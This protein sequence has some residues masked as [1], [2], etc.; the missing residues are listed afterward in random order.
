M[1]TRPYRSRCSHES[2]RGGGKKIVFKRESQHEVTTAEVITTNPN[3]I[4]TGP[5]Q[6]VFT[7]F[8]EETLLK[9][10]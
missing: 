7:M 8:Q 5:L 10:S 9:R 6:Q 3:L 4:K 1:K 2:A